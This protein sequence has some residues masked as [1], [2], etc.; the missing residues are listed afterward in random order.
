MAMSI[1]DAFKDGYSHG[2]SLASWNA[3]EVQFGMTLERHIDW[4]GVGTIDSVESWLEAFDRV[5]GAADESSRCYSP[6]ECIAADINARDE[7]YGE[8]SAEDGWNAFERGM[9]KGAADYRRKYYPV[10]ALRKDLREWMAE[11]AD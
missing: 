7:A 3:Q 2:W 10:R 8:C 9:N 1:R 11:S 5:I 6:F 4:V